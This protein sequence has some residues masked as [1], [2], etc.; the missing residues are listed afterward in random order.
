MAQPAEYNRRKDFTDQDGDDTDHSALNQEF[1]AAAQSINGIRLNLALIQKDDGALANQSVGSDQLR[2]GVFDAY[3]GELNQKVQEAKDASTQSTLSATASAESA[4][5]AAISEENAARSESNAAASAGSAASAAQYAFNGIY[6]GPHG[7]D[8]ALDPNGNPP[9]DGDFYYNTVAKTWRAYDAETGRWVAPILSGQFKRQIYEATT[10]YAPGVTDELTLPGDPQTV[11]NIFVHFDGIFQQANTFTLDGLLLKFDAPIPF[12]VQQVE[13]AYIEAVTIVVT[14]ALMS[15]ATRAE[16][17]SALADAVDGQAYEI[18][19]DE[20]AAGVLTRGVV[21]SGVLVDQPIALDPG[22]VVGLTEWQGNPTGVQSINGGQLSGM[23]NKIINGNFG[24]N[25]RSVS[26][27]VTL[28]AGAYGHDRWKAGA[29]GCTYT[30]A[31]TQ[32]VTTITITS[33]SLVQV[34]EGLNLQSGTHVLS[35]QG[36]AQG[37]VDGGAYGASG[38]VT[39]TAV[40]G[41]NQTIE[42]NT[43]TVSLVQYE[44]GTVATPFEFR[45][46]G[47][48]LALCKRYYEYLSNGQAYAG[49]TQVAGLNYQRTSFVK[50]EVTKR[51]A[52][53]CRII[54]YW[55]GA[56]VTTLRV[57]GGS[58]GAD[59]SIAGIVLSGLDGL[60]GICQSAAPSASAIIYNRFIADAEL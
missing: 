32:N 11:R 21:M 19:A 5:S 59:A 60:V 26:G 18:R 58:S 15:F 45:A 12:G 44:P 31:T 35:W 37:R 43:G 40:G 54:D 42:F 14:D 46:Y 24:V 9:T 38:G 49:F 29:S 25:Q 4:E 2:P 16:A 3:Q 56:T 33:G 6:F 27:T 41:T 48:E 51:A 39:G 10:D 20:S 52:P 34:I 47:I 28:A 36:T 30:Y 22:I 17:A 50:F 53:S 7:D 55:T 1:D 13:I 23:R 57:G 8:P